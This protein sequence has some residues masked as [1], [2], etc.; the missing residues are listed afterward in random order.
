MRGDEGM[1]KRPTTNKTAIEYE[2][3]NGKSQRQ[4]DKI[5][6]GQIEL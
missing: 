6:Y 4:K 1:E 5:H 3:K 2:Q